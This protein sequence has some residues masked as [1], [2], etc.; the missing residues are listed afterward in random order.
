MPTFLHGN[1]E[2]Y[3]QIINQ[4]NIPWNIFVGEG[5]LNYGYRS[6][7]AIL[8]SRLMEAIILNLKKDGAFFQYYQSNNGIGIGEKNTL[9]GLAPVGLFLETLGVRILSTKRVA[10]EGCNPFPWTVTIKFRGLTIIRQEMN[11]RII[12]SNDQLVEINDQEPRVIS[13]E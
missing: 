6:E 12:F 10:I 5:L 7:T 2:K 1:Q 11:T 13:I 4:V 3:G 8:I 9:H